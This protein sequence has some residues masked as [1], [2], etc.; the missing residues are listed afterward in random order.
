MLHI[1]TN[2]TYRHL[3]LAQVVALVGTGGLRRA[4]PATGRT[5][6]ATPTRGSRLPSRRTASCCRP[7]SAALPPTA[8]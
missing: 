5:R 1:L 6:P 8:D 2:R 7:L 3:F 4:E